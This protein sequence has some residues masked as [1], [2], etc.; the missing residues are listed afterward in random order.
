MLAQRDHQP[1]R[2]RPVRVK[3][4]QRR[5]HGARG[6]LRRAIQRLRQRQQI[7]RLDLVD[8]DGVRGG[9]QRLGR[10]L[11]GRWIEQRGHATRL[12]DGEGGFDRNQRGLELA[13]N[14]ARRLDG[15]ARRL[16][17][18]SGEQ[19]V[20]ARVHR[21]AVAAVG[22]DQP[23]APAR[24]AGQ[25]VHVRRRQAFARQQRQQGVAGRVV[26]A[27]DQRVHRHAQA[28]Q[29]HGH[30]QP[31]AARFDLQVVRL[32]RFAGLRQARHVPA[33]GLHE[34]AQHKGAGEGRRGHDNRVQSGSC[35]EHDSLPRKS[36][37]H[38]IEESK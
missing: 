35:A 7:N 24:R 12:G 20:G 11:P 32:Q 28:L 15:A 9:A 17:M 16:G 19:P 36:K 21:N 13:I 38:E 3:A 4:R 31:L 6:T 5:R 8:D 37:P 29:A 18:G 23:G 2:R 26:A 34:I 30:V 22:A 27:A 1:T 10:R 14:Q 33:A 25:P